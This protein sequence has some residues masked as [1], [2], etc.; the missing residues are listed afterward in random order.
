MSTDND[1]TIERV[2]DGYVA[3]KT[4][5]PAATSLEI[6]DVEDVDITD[7]TTTLDNEDV[8]NLPVEN[9][10]VEKEAKNLEDNTP[11]KKDVNETKKPSRAKKRIKQLH[12]EK[13]AAEQRAIAAE[14][15]AL[16]LETQ[17][18]DTSVYNKTA[19][20]AALEANLVNLRK[21]MQDAIEDGDAEESVRL[22]EELINCKTKLEA[23]TYELEVI[24]ANKEKPVKAPE[25]EQRVYPEKTYEWLEDYPQFKEGGLFYNIASL[26][27]VE[28]E[29]EGYSLD[30][31]DFYEELNSRLAPRFPEVFGTQ[32]ENDV[33]YAEEDK[34][35]SDTNEV[36]STDGKPTDDTSQQQ[37]DTGSNNRQVEQTVSGASRTPLHQKGKIQSRANESV[38]LSPET[39]RQAERWG[40]SLEQVARRVAH[41]Q[42]NKRGDGYTPIMIPHNKKA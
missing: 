21:G 1:N 32:E 2:S 36:T 35:S 20:K 40:L 41:N 23:L 30:N 19:M 25:V 4:N 37:N 38:P 14:K 11:V 34:N 6:K 27:S 22:N 33:N 3:I 39:V 17:L 7:I 8:L 24:E 29:N 42:K 18:Q 16:E 10:E 5:P 28:L 13:T 12:T 26:V 31:D 15:R 9:T